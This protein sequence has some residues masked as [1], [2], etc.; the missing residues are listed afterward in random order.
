MLSARLD[1]ARVGQIMATLPAR[2]KTAVEKKIYRSFI[3]HKRNH[4][5]Y[6]YI[7]KEGEKGVVNDPFSA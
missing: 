3:E 6:I 4:P 5:S 7:K 2:S 1:R